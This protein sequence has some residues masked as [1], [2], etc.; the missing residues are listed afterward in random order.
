MHLRD[1]TINH[2]LCDFACLGLHR[3]CPIVM[4]V[5]V[6]TS[7]ISI[8]LQQHCGNCESEILIMQL[9]V[10]SVSVSLKKSMLTLLHVKLMQLCH[11]AVLLN[12]NKTAPHVGAPFVRLF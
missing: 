4:I 12:G 2:I 8:L 3:M 6:I 9:L 5:S 1:F 7:K 10:D 11:S